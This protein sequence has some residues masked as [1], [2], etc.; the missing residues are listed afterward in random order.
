MIL[1]IDQFTCKMQFQKP[2]EMNALFKEIVHTTMLLLVRDSDDNWEPLEFY[3]LQVMRDAFY[4]YNRYQLENDWCR[5]EMMGLNKDNLRYF[6]ARAQKIRELLFIN[7]YLNK[8]VALNEISFAYYCSILPKIEEL[9]EEMKDNAKTCP[10]QLADEILWV[11]FEAYRNQ[12][13]KIGEQSSVLISNPYKLFAEGMETIDDFISKIKEKAK[14]ND[15]SKLIYRGVFIKVKNIIPQL[16]EQ[17]IP[18]EQMD[19]FNREY[20]GIIFKGFGISQVGHKLL[21]TNLM[22]V[23]RS[24]HISNIEIDNLDN[25][26]YYIIEAIYYI[27]MFSRKILDQKLPLNIE[28]ISSMY[29]A[30]KK[31]NIG[32]IL[33]PLIEEIIPLTNSM[34]MPAGA[35]KLLMQCIELIKPV[36]EKY[37]NSNSFA[38]KKS[39]LGS[40]CKINSPAFFPSLFDMLPLTVDEAPNEKFIE[41]L[42]CCI[43]SCSYLHWTTDFDLKYR[44]RTDMIVVDEVDELETLNQQKFYIVWYMG[45]IL[46]NNEDLRI[47]KNIALMASL[48]PWRID[49]ES[50]DA[51]EIERRVKYFF[52][53][54]SIHDKFD[55]IGDY[56][57]SMTKRWFNFVSKFVWNATQPL[58]PEFVKESIDVKYADGCCNIQ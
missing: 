33:K 21:Q 35:L 8:V 52:I 47:P 18:K 57:K 20:S 26:D 55:K 14:T 32:K 43:I 3:E 40:N 37:I 51:R 42:K 50:E 5:F 48:I 7:F 16:K 45:I 41:M 9:Y 36:E 39:L 1:L 56:A 13:Q 25:D 58:D 4:T 12:E 19:E 2:D 24:L 29:E 10:K 17:N 30:H 44:K 54:T 15:Y 46:N 34:F 53:E 22:L 11:D 49:D 27:H 38:N 6:H 23:K 31:D 28:T